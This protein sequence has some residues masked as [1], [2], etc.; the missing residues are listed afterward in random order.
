[1]QEYK[2]TEYIKNIPKY[3]KVRFVSF[4]LPANMDI[5]QDKILQITWSKTPVAILI[6]SKEI[7]DNYRRYFNDVWKQAKE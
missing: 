6:H 2:K 4:P 5:Y 3:M 1:M 7:A